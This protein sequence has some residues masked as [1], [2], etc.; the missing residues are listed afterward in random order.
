MWTITHFHNERSDGFPLGKRSRTIHLPLTR[1]SDSFDSPK[2]RSAAFCITRKRLLMADS[3][4]TLAV[5][6]WMESL[7]DELGRC[8]ENIRSGY[9]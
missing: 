8:R 2:P 4:N 9:V 3:Y 7:G 6:Y 5:Y 1:G